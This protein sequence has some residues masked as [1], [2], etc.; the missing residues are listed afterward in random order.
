MRIYSDVLDESD[1]AEAVR[2]ARSHGQDIYRDEMR[3]HPSRKAK[4]CIVLYCEAHNGG[5]S[6]NG[7]P[8]LAATWDAYGYMMVYL[9][10]RDPSAIVGQYNGVDDFIYLC[11]MALGHRRGRGR[12]GDFLPLLVAYHN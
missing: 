8:G 10:N 4:R 1:V 2:Y 5:R 6:R 3:Q 9:F 12:T 7:R 11:S